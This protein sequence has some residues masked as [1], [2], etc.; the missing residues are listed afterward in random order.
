MTQLPK[1]PGRTTPAFGFYYIER[2]LLDCLGNR[3][4]NQEEKERVFDFFGQWEA[5]LTCAFCGSPED[6][7]WDHVIPVSQGGET[8]LGN[9]VRACQP[10]DDSKGKQHFEE[11]MTG[12]APKSPRSQGITNVQE[13]IQHIKTYIDTFGYVARPLEERLT[14]SEMERVTE[15][16]TQLD[17][18]H[19]QVDSLI[20]D[21]RQRTGHK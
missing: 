5:Q 15:I 3:R 12:D 10:C 11:W 8:V 16:R 4:F 20:S 17:T 14:H 13:R 7:R 6:K 18:L 19:R 2:S 9:M 21:Y 1:T